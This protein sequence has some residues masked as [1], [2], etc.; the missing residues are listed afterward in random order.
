[1]NPVPD[2]STP[3]PQ[4]FIKKMAQKGVKESLFGYVT[5]NCIG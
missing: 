3:S 1:M 4:E 2:I 5:G